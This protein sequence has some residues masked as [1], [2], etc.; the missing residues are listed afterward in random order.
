MKRNAN[1][2]QAFFFY[3][4]MVLV[5]MGKWLFVVTRPLLQDWRRSE[6]PHKFNSLNTSHGLGQRSKVK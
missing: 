5:I 4:S 2:Y 6:T 3:T 1:Y